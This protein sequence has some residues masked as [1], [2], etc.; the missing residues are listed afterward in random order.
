[1]WHADENM[2]LVHYGIVIHGCIDGFSRTITYLACNTNN[3]SVTV[4]R[5]FY[6]AI[7][8]FGFPSHV[9]TDKGMENIRIGRFMLTVKV[10]T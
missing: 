2:K 7:V 4:G 1:M 9:R 10:Y 8:R 5:L 6:Q 3:R